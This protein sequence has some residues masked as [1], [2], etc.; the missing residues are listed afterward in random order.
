VPF[1]LAQGI[2]T[3]SFAQL[4]AGGRKAVKYSS[5][6][7]VFLALCTVALGGCQKEE[8]P[9]SETTPDGIPGVIVTNARLVLPAVK[10]NPGVVY[11]DIVNSGDE[12]VAM[13]TVDVAGAKSAMMHETV[14][15][16]GQT[17][18]AQMA[19]LTL[20]KGVPVKF[21]PGGKHVMAMDL[22]PALKVGDTT[23]I[24]A[25]FAGGD[26]MSFPAK[27]EAPGS[28]N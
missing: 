4:E 27:I 13:R 18:M 17:S 6:A 19:P 9:P 16:N 25:T 11:F 3:L 8:S 1:F 23:E 2:R 28:A 24:T 15:E 14:T 20:S 21:E 22:D 12:F 26:K 10:G 7:P 5:V